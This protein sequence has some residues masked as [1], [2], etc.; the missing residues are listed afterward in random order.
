MKGQLNLDGAQNA[1]IDITTAD[2]L[3][4]HIKLIPKFTDFD[5]KNDF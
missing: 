5:S 1:A 4:L 3:G 2:T